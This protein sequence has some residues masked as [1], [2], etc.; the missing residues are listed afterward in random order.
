MQTSPFIPTRLPEFLWFVVR[1]QLWRFATIALCTLA[2]PAGE[3]LIPYG[4]KLIVDG[5]I[6]LEKTGNAEGFYNGIYFTCAVFT[7][8][9]FLF[10]CADFFQ[11]E[12]FSRFKAGLRSTMFNHVQQH[13]YQFFIDHFA[14]AVAN[15]IT[16][17]ARSGGE[18]VGHLI[19]GLIP[20][21][22]I[23]VLGLWFLSITH[24][25]F[26]LAFGAWIALHLGIT[27]WLGRTSVKRSQYVSETVSAFNGAIV[28]S[29]SNN[30]NAR[31]FARIRHESSHIG[32]YIETARKA[33]IGEL[34]W[35]FW[36]RVALGT[37]V[38]V[39][40]LGMI[41]LL[42]YTWQQQLITLGDF[43]LVLGVT[44]N[45]HGMI[46][47]VSQVL[48]HFF[49][50][51][52]TC[53]DA[54][55]LVT[56]PLTVQDKPGAQPIA[57]RQGKIEFDGVQFHYKQG[58][59][60]FNDKDLVIEGGQKIGLVGFS[61]AGKSTFVHLILRFYDVTGGRILI[62]GQNIS[63]IQQESLRAQIAMIPQD[64]TLFHRTLMENIRYGKLDATDE[65]VKHA[66]KLAYC[67]EFIAALPEGYESLVGERGVKLSGG[68][69]QRIA[70]ARAILKNAPILILDEATSALDSVT[71]HY[72]KDA[73][74]K[75]MLGRTTIVIAHRLST[76]AD[77]DRILVFQEGRITEDGNH[78]ELLAAGGHYASL[79]NMQA[80]GF[81][82]EM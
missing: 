79:W 65:E 67:E 54:L 35:V 5:V 68:Q 2:W 17:M 46:W 66:A 57:I 10:R 63:D 82:P 14:G 21:M 71:E 52:G 15:K 75:L 78:Q 6:A 7:L 50:E 16:Q 40:L 51:W 19:F 43:L 25:W 32:N 62:D 1:P 53:H 76:L 37:N 31:L 23:I 48:M 49:A 58:R 41:W 26:A 20:G 80:G 29:L 11:I 42:F 74:S 60:I 33:G 55:T 4:S 24:I 22:F 61:G 3:V 45:V 27:L 36:M 77:M 18:V 34:S 69:R 9:F 12:A 28:D 56:A 72:I 30:L 47:H 38:L 64:T 44:F 13:S 39:M 70:I 8:S 73:L 81:L 59:N